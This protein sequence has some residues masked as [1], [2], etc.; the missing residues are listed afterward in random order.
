MTV[1]IS[2]TIFEDLSK[3]S[4]FSNHEEQ[5]FHVRRVHTYISPTT[6]DSLCA[7]LTFEDGTEITIPNCLSVITGDY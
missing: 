1:R 3:I 5:Y 2:F 6:R 4:G 7:H